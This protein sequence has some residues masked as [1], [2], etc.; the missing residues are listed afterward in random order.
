MRLCGVGNLVLRRGL[1][2][3]VSLGYVYLVIY[4]GRGVRQLERRLFRRLRTK[5]RCTWTFPEALRIFK[6]SGGVGVRKPRCL[7]KVEVTSAFLRVDF[8][9]PR[10]AGRSV[11]LAQAS[12][13]VSQEQARGVVL[14]M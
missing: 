7:L 10:E 8:L 4:V 9:V 1:F 2:P 5:R 13:E 3:F 14:Q 11:K 6:A 12:E